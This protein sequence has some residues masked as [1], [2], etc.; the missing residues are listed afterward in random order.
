MANKKW[1]A[2]ARQILIDIERI[3][4]D[5]YSKSY[6]QCVHDIFNAMRRIVRRNASFGFV[7]AVHGRWE[8]MYEGKYANPRFRCSVCKEKSLF[9]DER[10]VLGNWIQVQALTPFCPHCGAALD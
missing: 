3:Y 7:E 2:D 9:K 10:N 8:D 1:V 4:E 5:Y 6:D